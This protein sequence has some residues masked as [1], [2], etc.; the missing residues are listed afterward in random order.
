M[1]CLTSY[2]ALVGNE[3]QHRVRSIRLDNSREQTG[4]EFRQ[5]IGKNAMTAGFIPPFASQSN[6]AAERLI[7][8]LWKMACEMLL[9]ST[10]S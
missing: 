8:E 6:E 3:T 5:F 2:K 10:L 1:D 7:Q 9:N 4:L